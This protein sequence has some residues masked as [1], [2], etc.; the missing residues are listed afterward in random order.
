HDIK[1]KAIW[2]VLLACLLMFI[3]IFIRFRGWQYGLGAV[4]ALFHDALM[5]MAVFTLFKDV[6]PFS[7]E[8]NQ[9]FIAAILT[10]MSYSMTDT[11]VVFDRIREYLNQKK[12]T[13]GEDKTQIINYALNAT[14][15][16][17]INTSMSIFFVLLAIFIFGGTTIKGF[18]FA[19]LVGI[20]VG[21]YS[22]ICIATP[23]VIDF[24]RK[25]KDVPKA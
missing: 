2:S 4:V 22:S 23:I 14:L 15:S 7:L 16:R 25:K 11:V 24:D 3:F 10:V 13:Q 1:S 21:T 9:D 19:L 8:V 5:I 17:T 6:V 12:K 18:A 20:V